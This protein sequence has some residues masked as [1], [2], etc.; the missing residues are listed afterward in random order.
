MNQ[1]QAPGS[2]PAGPAKRITLSELARQTSDRGLAILDQHD[3]EMAARLTKMRAMRPDKPTVVVVGEAKR[4]KSSLTNA[5]INVPGLSPVDSRVATSTYIMF[6]RGPKTAARALLPGQQE[7]VDVP[8]DRM[9]DWATDLG[10]RGEYTPP[11]LIEVECDSPLLGNLNL[12]DTPGVGGLDATHAEI[13]LRAVG[14]ATALLFVCDASAPFT[15]PEIDFLVKASKNIDLVIFAV[16]KTDAY[17]GWRQIVEDNRRLLREHAPRFANSVM[18]PVSAKLFEQAALMGAN[19]LGQA[20]RTE[21]NITDLQVAL[22]Q[23]VATKA[24]ALHEAN[25]LRTMRSQLDGLLTSLEDSRRACQPDVEYANRLKENRDRLLQARKADSRAWQ[26]RL[27]S[28]LSRAR[29]DTMADIQS[30]NRKFLTYWRRQVE[31][32]DKT[33]LRNIGPQL[34]MALK[35][36][37]MQIFDR[38]QARM[39]GVSRSVLQSMFAQNELAE[40]Y[41]ALQRPRQVTAT[42]GP[43]KRQSSADE[44]V[45]TNISMMSGIS[46]T[47][48]TGSGLTAATGAAIVAWP[49]AVAVG[50]S[51]AGWIVWARRTA[52]DRNQLKVWLNETLGETRARLE[53]D[54]SAYFIEAEHELTLALDRAL[55]RRIETLDGHIKQIDQSLKVDRGERE[56]RAAQITKQI[57]GVRDVA[58]TID[59]LLPRLR[60]AVVQKKRPAEAT[61]Q[62]QQ[63]PSQPA[64]P[65]KDVEP[66]P[67]EDAPATSEP[68]PPEPRPATTAPPAEAATPERAA[69][70][71]PAAPPEPSV[72]DADDARPAPPRPLPPVPTDPPKP[73]RAPQSVA[74]RA[75]AAAAR[76][77]AKRA[78]EQA[79]HGSAAEPAPAPEVGEGAPPAPS[80]PAKPPFESAAPA[81]RPDDADPK[82]SP[83]QSPRPATGQFGTTAGQRGAQFGNFPGSPAGQ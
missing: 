83:A 79:E 59:Q 77:A 57:A 25:L 81:D 45:L 38:Q 18:L 63:A 3:P 16:T 15:K 69:Q 30:E 29:L 21:S 65:P 53:A 51:V 8:M 10:N 26:L 17:R 70:P 41:A 13:A 39:R 44:K 61:P 72:A 55:V 82:P 48:I 66:A 60:N 5:L 73:E 62:S 78:A 2:A 23:Q 12:V 35:A 24:S 27:R 14:R 20:L 43:A 9:R 6:R 34:D 56:R 22:Q 71:E 50:L 42:A 1:P 52:S 7:P 68:A 80:G 28:L 76:L 19:D 40:V 33:R 54:A 67:P 4:G 47:S 58:S 37:S 49:I 32:M 75:R 31:E 74:D 46:I 36:S 64:P 11:R